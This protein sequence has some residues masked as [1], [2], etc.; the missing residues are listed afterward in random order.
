M[1][2]P[3]PNRVRIVNAALLGGLALFSM[4]AAL[5]AATLVN[6][7]HFNESS[8]MTAADSVGSKHGTLMN[9][10]YFTGAGSVYLGS[11]GLPSSDTSGAYVVLPQNLVTGLT[12]ITVETWYTPTHNSAPFADWNRIWDFWNPSAHF[13]FRS[14]NGTFGV[15]G[16]ITTTSSSQ[17]LN[18]PVV[19][20]GTESH[21]VWTSDPVSGRAKIYVNGVEVASATGFTNTP[22]ALGPTTNWLGRSK[23]GADPYLAAFIDE[24]RIYDGVLGPLEAAASFQAGAD[25]PG[26]NYGAVTNITLVVPGTL[27]VGN[28]VQAQVMAAASGLTNKAV[29]VTGAAELSYTSSATSIITVDT[30]GRL[31][32]AA[33]GS[34]TITAAYVSGGQTNTSA[35]V[36]SV[37]S[38]PATLIHRY[39]FD[40]DFSTTAVDSI[41]GSNGIVQLSG[42]QS[43]GNVMLDGQGLSYVDLPAGM[44]STNTI[45]NDAVT[46]ETWVTFPGA[47][48][49][50]VNL[51]AFGNTVSGAG[52]N[53]IFFTPHSG[54]GDYRF[55]ASSTQPGWSGNGE[56]GAIVPGNLDFR[57]NIHIACVMNFGRD[58]A[59]IYV[60]GALV[61]YNAN[62][63]RELSQIINN[64]SYLGKSTYDDPLCVVT[65]DEFRIYD[66]ALS[67]QQIV[68]AYQAFGPN[69][70]NNSPGAFQNLALSVPATLT[71]SWQA[72]ATV[73][74]NWQNATNVNLF[75][76][77]DF[78]L[79]SSDTNVLTITAAGLITAR[80]HGTAIITADYQGNTA[81]QS[82]TVVTPSA[83]LVHR[84]SFDQTSGNVVPDLIGSA[85]GYI[86]AGTNTLGVT[87]ASWTG[88][89]Q[90]LINTDISLGA[91]DAYVDLP[92][93][94]ISA[95]T[96]NASFEVWVTAYNPDYW[97]RIFDFGSLPGP[98]FPSEP[99]LFLTRGGRL[100]WSVGAIDGGAFAAGALT[101][102]VVLYNDLE[103]QSKLYINGNQ[104][105]MSAAGAASIALSS[106]NDTNNWLGRSL[107]S[108]PIT[109]EY[110]DPY[111]Q[112]S[113]D[114]F[115]IYSGLLTP[116]Q[117]MAN[118]IAGPNL[119]APA[120][121]VTHGGGNL[122]L[123]WPTNAVG[124]APYSSAVLGSGAAWSAVSGSPT[125]S[126]ANYQLS[127]PMT[128]SARFFRLQN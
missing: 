115:R 41:R 29:N 91:A 88:T 26:S 37:L 11:F 125:L 53:Y 42:I 110:Y 25:A 31:T 10:A 77:L 54:L 49:D 68:A 7:Y 102:L 44:I 3:N 107:Y 98:P 45:A 95:L 22:A 24:F 99:N 96:N 28:F 75:G 111:L 87:N 126:G 89:G 62:F 1:S 38:V 94:I 13:F 121:T 73:L 40:D 9:S 58:L 118:Y 12:A 30:G 103:N 35:K 52:G 113:Y 97:S 116:Q 2:N 127:V 66:G 8:G 114:E 56:Q 120:L 43:G 21:V 20:D 48:A 59:A 61:G 51:F 71:A 101:H 6:R 57:T 86:A 67:A 83:T 112:A 27:P 104:A 72:Q 100:D 34:A 60:N 76:D 117:I 123:L 122:N 85:H 5:G 69:A 74:G 119:Q 39:S 105:A 32:A 55:I 64:Y 109:P 70:T 15:L 65:I 108:A 17:G 18:G 14:G 90:L 93:G 46:F 84:Y 4:Q 33:P 63:A 128:N 47:N 81:T 16:D 78:K 124:Y 106:I 50:W 79:S 80:N 36:V 92:D 23:Y 82:V 19:P